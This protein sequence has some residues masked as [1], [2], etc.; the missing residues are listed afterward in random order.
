M[1]IRLFY[2]CGAGHEVSAPTP[3]TKC[4]L[5]TCKRPQL[6]RVG[7]GSKKEVAAA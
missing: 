7:P 3:V 4:P 1:S 6:K 5:A 2:V